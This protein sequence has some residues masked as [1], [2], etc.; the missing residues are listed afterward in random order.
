MRI[1]PIPDLRSTLKGVLE[2]ALQE[3]GGVRGSIVL[4]DPTHGDL[5]ILEKID[6]QGPMAP[7]AQSKGT[8]SLPRRR[9]DC[10]PG[11]ADRPTL[12]R[13]PWPRKIRTSSLLK[14]CVPATG[15]SLP[16]LSS[17]RPGRNP[18]PLA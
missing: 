17:P 16:F 7:A 13:A 8:A 9:R 14:S 10:W 4:V 11:G 15:L 18:A 6:P 5:V 2:K 3:T 12:L 1:N